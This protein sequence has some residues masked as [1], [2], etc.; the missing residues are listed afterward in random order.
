VA[1]RG[2]P[3]VPAHAGEIAASPRASQWW[4]PR[5]GGRLEMVGA[6]KW[7]APR[8]D[9]LGWRPAWMASVVAPADQAI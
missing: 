9:G 8:D 3:G 5:N 7:W 6:S 1:R 4:A 2:N